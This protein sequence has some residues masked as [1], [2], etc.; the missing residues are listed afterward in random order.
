MTEQH[1]W[2]I[3]GR[4]VFI[5]RWDDNRLETITKEEAELRLNEYETLKRATEALSAEDAQVGSQYL[6]QHAM[7][8]VFPSGES[9]GKALLLLK[10]IMAHM[11]DY[12]D[13]LEKP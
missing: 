7:T 5:E 9:R 3:E 2:H 8:M 1:K 10:R 13:I 11:Q 6:H 4:D 12:A